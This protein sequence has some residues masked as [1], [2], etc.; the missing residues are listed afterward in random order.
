MTYAKEPVKR[1]GLLY[2]IRRNASEPETQRAKSEQKVVP[3]SKGGAFDIT[4]KTSAFWFADGRALWI[5]GWQNHDALFH[6]L[7]YDSAFSHRPEAGCETL[8]SLWEMG[9]VRVGTAPYGPSAGIRPLGFNLRGYA[10]YIKARL[11]ET[12]VWLPLSQLAQIDITLD[13]VERGTDV[14]LAF[15]NGTLFGALAWLQAGAPHI[16]NRRMK[17]GGQGVCNEAD[18]ERPARQRERLYAVLDALDDERAQR[19]VRKLLAMDTVEKEEQKWER[20]R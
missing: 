19:C 5:P 12:L 8:M 2:E 13:V 17:T 9:V 3:L 14:D 16:G 20:Q 4:K 18:P 1:Q 7:R 10:E 15:F 11:H 6:A